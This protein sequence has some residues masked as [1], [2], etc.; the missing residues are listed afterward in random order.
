MRALDVARCGLSLTPPVMCEHVRGWHQ[1]TPMFSTPG[2]VCPQPEPNATELPSYA[3]ISARAAQRRRWRRWWRGDEGAHRPGPEAQVL[4][5]VLWYALR[6]ALR[7][8]AASLACSSFTC[9]LGKAWGAVEHDACHDE[10]LYASVLRATG[11]L[12]LPMRG[13]SAAH[14]KAEDHKSE[15]AFTREQ[16][17]GYAFKRTAY[18]KC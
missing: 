2:S 16:Q 17:F 18:S 5:H 9:R 14:Y 3:P 8:C 6:N 11:G 7:N 10:H 15:R 12:V 4:R 13:S 1:A